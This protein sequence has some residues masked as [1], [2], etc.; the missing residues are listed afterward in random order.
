MNKSFD[1]LALLYKISYTAIFKKKKKKMLALFQMNHIYKCLQIMKI[2]LNHKL[3][4]LFQ[5]IKFLNSFL[6]TSMTYETLRLLFVSSG[7]F[8]CLL[9][10]LT[11]LI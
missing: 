8:H 4:V 10:W 3:L 11:Q 7:S 5:V 1:R 6:F 2:Q 9:M